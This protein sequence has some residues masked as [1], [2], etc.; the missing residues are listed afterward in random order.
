VSQGS[1]TSTPR[2][3]TRP[4]VAWLDAKLY[5]GVAS[6][7]D[8]ERLRAEVLARLQPEHRMLD[9]GAGAG[10]VPQMDFRGRAAQVCGVDP[11]P[12]VA[13]NPHLDEARVGVGEQIPYPDAHFDLVV[14]DNVLEHLDDP[15]RVFAEIARVLKPGGAFVAKTPN[16]WHYMPTIARFT[17]LSFHRYICRLR[18]RASV[19]T[20][21]TRY[22]ANTPSAIAAV[23]ARHGLKLET[24]ATHE[25]RPEY[26][27]ISA[28][29]YLVGWMYERAVNTLPG[30]AKLR[31]VLIAVLRKEALE[32]RRAA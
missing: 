11:D 29:T 16:A 24:S 5:P 15:D 7:W 20:F 22:R 10:I 2:R 4:L 3:R 23:G 18:G 13:S 26:L 25:D 6:R 32:A 9:L 17:P 21:P 30:G 31:S 19:D 1:P 28:P 12:R 8:D 14:A 27:R